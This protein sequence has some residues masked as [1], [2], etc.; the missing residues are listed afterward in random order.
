[1]DTPTPGE[2]AGGAEPGNT[3]PPTDAPTPT[4][5][6]K[7]VVV[8][9]APILNVRRTPSADGELVQT[10]EQGDQFDVI[11]RSQDGGWVQIGTDGREVGWVSSEFVVEQTVA[12]APAA[13]DT[14]TGETP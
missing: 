14:S 7:A 6:T 2:A 12:V 13:P 3:T 8:V 5:A 11:G 4:P 1:V 10:V 9:N